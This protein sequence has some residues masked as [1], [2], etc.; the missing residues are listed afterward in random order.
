MKSDNL[1]KAGKN[2][3]IFN[4]VSSGEQQAVHAKLWYLEQKGLNQWRR[5]SSNYDVISEDEQRFGGYELIKR[6]LYATIINCQKV[7][8]SFKIS[9]DFQIADKIGGFQ[10]L[11]FVMY[12][13]FTR[14]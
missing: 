7:Q 3:V 2:L 8:T 10:V 12:T 9:K 5:A 6:H 13:S 4:Y 11:L 14:T 1:D